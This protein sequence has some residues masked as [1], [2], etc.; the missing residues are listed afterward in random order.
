[1]SFVVGRDGNISLLRVGTLVG[2]VGV[3]LVVGGVAAYVLDQNSY[4][5]PL[6]VDPY[7]SA[8]SWGNVREVGSSRRLVFRIY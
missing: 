3:L 2:I 6:D 5:V 4:K 7:P 8:E 1:M